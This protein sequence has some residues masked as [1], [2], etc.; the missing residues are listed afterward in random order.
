MAGDVA[1]YYF[2]VAD[3]VGHI[4]KMTGGIPRFPALAEDALHGVDLHAEV[5]R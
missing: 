2:L 1:A 3:G 4:V 5:R